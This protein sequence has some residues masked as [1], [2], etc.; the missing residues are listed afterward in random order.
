MSPAQLILLLIIFLIITRVLLNLQSQRISLVD[1]LTWLVF[2]TIV[3]MIVAFP[4]LT[5]WLANKVGIS[6]G[7]GFNYLYQYFNFI[8]YYLLNLNTSKTN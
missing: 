1:C 4:D 8:F 2:W 3:G 5:Q 7:V 6:R